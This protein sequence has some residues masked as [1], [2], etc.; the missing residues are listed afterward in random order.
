MSDLL[1]EVVTYRRDYA[2]P[3]RSHEF[4][5]LSIILTLRIRCV[6]VTRES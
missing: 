6:A 2:E 4:L 3:A 1:Y 5:D